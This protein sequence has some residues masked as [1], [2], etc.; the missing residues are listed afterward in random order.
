MCWKHFKYTAFRMVSLFH[1]CSELGDIQS[2]C[3]C[4]FDRVL[5]T[6]GL[7]FLICEGLRGVVEIR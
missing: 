1:V 2:T 7:L 5:D 3:G 6:L 4:L